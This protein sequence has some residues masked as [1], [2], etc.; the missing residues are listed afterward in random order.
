MDGACRNGGTVRQRFEHD[1][2]G[3]GFV[4]DLAAR[5][6]TTSWPGAAAL[7]NLDHRGAAG[8]EPDTGDGAGHPDP[9][10]RRAS[11]ARS[12]TSP[13]PDP[14][15][16]PPA[17]LLPARHPD[18]RADSR[19]IDAARRRGG[20]DRPRL[21]RRPRRPGR[22]G[23]TAREVMPLFGQLFVAGAGRRD[24]HGARADGLLPAQARR[25]RD[26]AS[27]SPAC[28]PRDAR[29]QG[30]AHA[31]TSSSRSSPTCP[32][33]GSSR[34]LALVHSRFSHQHVPDLAARPPVPATSRTTARS[35]P[36]RATATG[37]GPARRCWPAR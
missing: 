13:L 2:C 5:A 11:C 9:G 1:A 21:A 22:L 24:R 16:T 32:T 25:A 23:A 18:D 34:A 4:A 14:A 28:R 37:C 12:S 20:P 36:C 31:P 19:Q 27:T 3:V 8:A 10:P 6:D 15:R 7:C 33:S 29:L 26:R 17:W 35:T 30:H